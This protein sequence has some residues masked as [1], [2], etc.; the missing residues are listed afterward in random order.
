MHTAPDAVTSLSHSAVCSLSA[1]PAHDISRIAWSA[2]SRL[3]DQLEW[4]AILAELTVNASPSAHKA[5]HEALTT[6]GDG[7]SAGEKNLFHEFQQL[8]LTIPEQLLWNPFNNTLIA[9]DQEYRVPQSSRVVVEQLSAMCPGLNATEIAEVRSYI[10]DTTGPWNYVGL[11]ES[12]K[13]HGSCIWAIDAEGDRLAPVSP[14]YTPGEFLARHSETIAA[15]H[16]E[17]QK[18]IAFAAS[19]NNNLLLDKTVE[20]RFSAG[21]AHPALIFVTISDE[22]GNDEVL[23]TRPQS[24]ED[25][26]ELARNDIFNLEIS[27]QAIRDELIE[28]IL[29][30]EGPWNEVGLVRDFFMSAKGAVL[31][32]LFNGKTIFIPISMPAGDFMSTFVDDNPAITASGKGLLNRVVEMRDIKM[33]RGSVQSVSGSAEEG[34][35][36]HGYKGRLQ[37]AFFSECE[38]PEVYFTDDPLLSERSKEA[39]KRDIDENPTA[40]D[41]QLRGYARRFSETRRGVLIERFDGTRRFVPFED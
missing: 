23:V 31:C 6:R 32:R 29:T 2:H 18:T 30:N 13:R 12:F 11:V 27:Q 35:M 8:A 7:L 21:S 25:F 41:W 4:G 28:H 36:V 26:L 24:S 16:P 17:S 40:P 19:M 39:L 1:I 34:V 37:G 14:L 38:N 9:D 10:Q 20:V 3:F 33:I 15:L 5:I 22:S